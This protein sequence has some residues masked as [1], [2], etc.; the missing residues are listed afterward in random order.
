MGFLEEE[1]KSGWRERVGEHSGEEAGPG[2]HVS[3][4]L[5]L[6]GPSV[7]SSSLPTM[8]CEGFFP[9]PPLYRFVH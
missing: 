5:S 8:G 4:F 7:S 3:P 6:P 1:V 2:C 9:L